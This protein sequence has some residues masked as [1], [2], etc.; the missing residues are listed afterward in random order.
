MKTD[1]MYVCMYVCPQN[2]YPKS[3]G[4]SIWVCPFNVILYIYIYLFIF[5]VHTCEVLIF[6]RKM[7]NQQHVFI[8]SNTKVLLASFFPLSSL[9]SICLFH[10]KKKEIDAARTHFGILL[11]ASWVSN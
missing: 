10:L 3:L 7:L 4:W 9:G 2:S 1:P 6:S 8:S 5:V 11:W